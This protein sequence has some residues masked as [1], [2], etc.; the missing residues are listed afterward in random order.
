MSSEVKESIT[1]HKGLDS[2]RVNESSICLI[3]GERSRLYYRGYSIADLTDN[4]SYEEVA[5]LLIIGQLPTQLQLDE[6][7][8]TLF[9]E[10]TLSPITMTLLKSY[11]S[12]SHP[13]DVLRTTISSLALEDG[14]LTQDKSV[15]LQRAIRILAKAPVIIA[16][17]ERIRQGKEPL[18]PKKEL[19]HAAN[20]LYMIHGEIPSNYDSRIM[21]IALSLHA[22]HEMNAST[23]SGIVTASTLSDMYS[24]IT[25]GIATLRGSLHGGANEEA[26]KMIMEI[27]TPENA[28]TF[29]EE[30][31]KQ[32]KRIMGFGHRIY[33]TYDPRYTILKAIAEKLG[34]VKGKASLYDTAVRVER[35]ALGRLSDSKI[36]PNV[37]F[38]SGLVFH[39]LGLRTDLFTPIFASSRIAGWAAHVLEYLEDNR[40]IRPKAVY[41]GKVDLQYT[42][43]E[44]RT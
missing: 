43:I 39:M 25:A 29:V 42:P 17:F 10:Y 28:V 31:L 12:T 6:L 32:K 3:D 15:N 34:G 9:S 18:T 2:I 19:G 24:I 1:I 33:K 14:G 38:Y 35:E 8:N 7:K 44:Q 36:F 26:L 11:P 41:T 21:D 16:A 4:A 22:E 5:Y 13:M 40:L 23:F 20:F 30:R 37:D 27:G